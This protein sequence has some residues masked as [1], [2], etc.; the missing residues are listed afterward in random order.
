MSVWIVP[1]LL[2]LLFIAGMVRSN[3]TFDSEPESK[4]THVSPWA[5]DLCGAF[6]QPLGS[7]EPAVQLSVSTVDP[8]FLGLVQA[9]GLLSL[10]QATVVLGMW[11]VRLQP[12]TLGPLVLRILRLQRWASNP[13]RAV[14]IPVCETRIP[15]CRSVRDSGVLWVGFCILSWVLRSLPSGCFVSLVA[16]CNISPSLPPPSEACVER[17]CHTTQLLFS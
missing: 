2:I 11:V 6:L 1:Y 10:V 15:P 4:L 7:E 5:H 17:S 13:Y 14:W 3:S 9:G 16:A 12:S 8:S